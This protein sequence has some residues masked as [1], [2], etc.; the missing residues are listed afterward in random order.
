MTTKK[1]N[2]PRRPPGWLGEADRRF[3]RLT[4]LY[5]GQGDRGPAAHECADR[6]E[7]LLDAIPGADETVH[8]AE[9]RA[10]IAELREQWADAVKHRTREIELI[11]VLR[12]LAPNEPPRFREL[13]LEINYDEASLADRYD[14]LALALW[15]S[16]RPMDALDALGTS[17]R[18]CNEAGVEF[19]GA[20]I[21]AEIE[22]DL[23]K[24]KR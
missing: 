5:Y 20:D 21:R 18:M 12:E 22:D 17:E 2:R 19:D 8:A 10:V 16:G 4:D 6:L 7:R 14:L 24:Q 13:I 3:E 11:R 9:Y 23:E 1:R 15:Y